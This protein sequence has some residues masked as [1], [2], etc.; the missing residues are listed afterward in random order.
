MRNE[1]KKCLIPFT[2]FHGTTYKISINLQKKV[3]VLYVYLDSDKDFKQRTDV[4]IIFDNF[5]SCKQTPGVSVT[6]P[7]FACLPDGIYELKKTDNST[8]FCLF[9]QPDS[10][11][12]IVARDVSIYNENV[13]WIDYLNFDDVAMD[14]EDTIIETLFWM[15]SCGVGLPILELYSPSE[16]SDKKKIR[17]ENVYKFEVVPSKEMQNSGT[18]LS[19]VDNNE[20]KK[21]VVAEQVWP[22]DDFN[23]DTEK[24]KHYIVPLTNTECV[25]VFAEEVTDGISKK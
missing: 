8:H 9:I 19:L 21:S 15:S 2:S 24:L 11:L 10:L 18:L 4:H 20:W 14:V 7:E 5:K 22:Y 1:Q 6:N 23:F 12:E 3:L 13:N 16:S 17:F 25:H